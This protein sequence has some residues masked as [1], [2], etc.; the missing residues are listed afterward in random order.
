MLFVFIFEIRNCELI[1]NLKQ[2]KCSQ[3]LRKN[4]CST[5]IVQQYCKKI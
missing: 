5:N 3:N 1:S 4:E 2:E